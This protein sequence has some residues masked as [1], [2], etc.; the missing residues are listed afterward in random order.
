MKRKYLLGLITLLVTTSFAGA[1]RSFAA[2]AVVATTS[3]VTKSTIQQGVQR[4]SEDTKKDLSKKHDNFYWLGQINKATIIINTD[5]GLLDKKYSADF[6][7]ALQTVIH[8]GNLFT[9]LCD[10]I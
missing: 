9:G 7:K 10:R 2:D 1:P 3:Q 6:A 8:N 5:E 4:L